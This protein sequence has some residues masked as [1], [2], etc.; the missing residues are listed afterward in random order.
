MF[1]FFYTWL[2]NRTHSL[3]LCVLLH[4]SFTAAMENLYLLDDG[5]AVDLAILGSLLGGVLVLLLLTR[6]TAGSQRA[7]DGDGDGDGRGNVDRGLTRR[8]LTACAQ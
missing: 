7:P 5:L 2:W 8:P 4:G 3:L 6:G 1:V